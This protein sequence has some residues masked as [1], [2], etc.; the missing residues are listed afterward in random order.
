MPSKLSEDAPVTFKGGHEMVPASGQAQGVR[1]LVLLAPSVNQPVTFCFFG[2]LL[3][4][5]L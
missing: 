3:I 5:V 2:A 1:F 4:F